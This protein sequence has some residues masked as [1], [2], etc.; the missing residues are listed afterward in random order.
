M[1]E[2]PTTVLA[3]PELTSAGLRWHPAVGQATLGGPLLRLADDCDRAFLILAAVFG[4]DEERHPAAISAELLHRLDYFSSFP[5][6]ATFPVALDGDED[7]L[8]GFAA[9]P[10][11]EAGL[12]LPR[13]GP[14]RAVLTP[15]ACYH[16]YAAHE[17]E[18][19]PAARY[20]TTAATCF[21]RE[22]AFEPL[23]RQWAFH[24]REVICAGTAAEVRRFLSRARELA[25]RLCRE[26]SL[27][28]AW[29]PATDSFFRPLTNPKFLLQK[30]SP[31]KEEAVIGG[32][33]AIVSVNLHHSH[34]GSAFG[35]SRAGQAAH[36]G[37]VAF[38]LERWLYALCSRHGAD[39][40]GWPSVADAARRAVA[41]VTAA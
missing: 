26:L 30:V 33:A 28:V 1:S 36:T 6:Q 23:V 22:A 11:G 27:P 14:V 3:G 4:A 34:I 7:N 18:E 37:C 8:A 2:V 16:I 21:R 19:L 5:H 17:G 41:G 9:D 40:A 24:M 20:F 25:D 15:A 13:L 12:Q 35:I 39:P 38:G 31:T 29:E 32:R 10:L